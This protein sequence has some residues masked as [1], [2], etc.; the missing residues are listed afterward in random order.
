MAPHP[1]VDTDS[2]KEVARKHLLGLL[3]GVRGKKNLV[4]EQSL[5][6]PIGLFVKFSTLQEYG[7]D[8]VFFLENDNLDSSQKNVI[9]LANGEK[10]SQCIAIA[11]QIKR[12]QQNSST[13]HDFS[14]IWVPRRTLVS[15]RILEESGVL[16]DIAVEILPLHFIP[17]DQDVLTLAYDDAFGDLYL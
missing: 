7:V 1:G 13:E 4:I 15:D 5:A 11:G 2:I 10:A 8:K 9:F 17:L 14:V 12:L 3:E 16:G 6:G